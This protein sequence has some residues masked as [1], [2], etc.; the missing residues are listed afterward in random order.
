MGSSEKSPLNLTSGNKPRSTGA[1]S[2]RSRSKVSEKSLDTK[3]SEP[4]LQVPL[5]EVVTSLRL[6]EP[7]SEEPV[8]A[9]VEEAPWPFANELTVRE[10]DIEPPAEEGEEFHQVDSLPENIEEY[11]PIVL[12]E[13]PSPITENVV[14]PKLDEIFTKTFPRNWWWKNSEE[15]D[16]VAISD[17]SSFW[18]DDYDKDLEA[19]LW[20]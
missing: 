6:P 7:V 20:I 5:Q 1:R 9:A 16:S 10:D 3:P 18:A 11:P 8:D 13:N 14:P 19:E 12:Q 17:D 2:R 15:K 4:E